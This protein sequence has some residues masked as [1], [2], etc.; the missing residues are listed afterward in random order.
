MQSIKLRALGVP[1]G[2]ATSGR[3][4]FLGALNEDAYQNGARAQ[5]FSPALKMSEY[6]AADGDLR[7]SRQPFLA[8]H[9][10][11]GSLEASAPPG[12]GRPLA[13]P[14]ACQNG[15]AVADSQGY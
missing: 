7:R 11:L 1:E 9:P 10:C 14:D 5:G 3:G 6:Q 4:Q 2:A 13:V 12:K 15:W 8:E